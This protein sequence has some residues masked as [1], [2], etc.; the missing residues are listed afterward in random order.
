MS[1]W[2][3]LW[4]VFCPVHLS[5]FKCLLRDLCLC[6]C[7]WLL[8]VTQRCKAREKYFQIIWQGQCWFKVRNGEG[9]LFYLKSLVAVICLLGLLS[10][11]LQPW[12]QRHSRCPQLYLIKPSFCLA[13]TVSILFYFFF[14]TIGSSNLNIGLCRVPVQERVDVAGIEYQLPF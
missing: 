4:V 5:I 3:N 11:W 12:E 8:V 2:G 9:S 13:H 14:W 6:V 10:L 1:S 7:V